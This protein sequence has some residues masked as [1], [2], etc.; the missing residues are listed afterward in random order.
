[1]LRRVMLAGI[2]ILMAA[3]V[4]AAAD[5]DGRWQGT[6]SGPN[7]DITLTFNF[8]ADGTKLTGTVETPNGETPISEGKVED[9]KISFK[10]HLNDDNN[11]EVD[12]EGTISG[13]SIDLKV[14]GPWGES[15]MTLKRVA[16]KEKSGA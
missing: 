14:T 3:V 15:N 7:G 13:D 5:V 11:T 1:M 10:T 9:N 4:S 8:K 12:H 16:E 6:I 2:L